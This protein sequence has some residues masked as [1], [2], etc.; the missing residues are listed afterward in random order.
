MKRTLASVLTGTL[1]AMAAVIGV[2]APASAA[3]YTLAGTTTVVANEK[4]DI[5]ITGSGY[6]DV[7]ALPGQ[8]GPGVYV[9]IVERGSAVADQ[10]S[11]PTVSVPV[12]ADGTIAST[13]SVPA[14]ALD[15]T[16]SYD[17]ISWPTRSVPSESNIFA[18]GQVEIDWNALFPPAPAVQTATTLS[19]S[20]ATTAVE[21]E[22]VLLTASV[23]PAAAGSVTFSSD[24]SALGSSPVTEG[25]AQLSTTTLAVGARSITASFTPADSAAFTASESVALGYTVTAKPVTPVSRLT[26]SQTEGL[27]PA[28]AQ[29]EI[30]GTGYEINRGGIYAQVGWLVEG[31]W[32]PLSQT[33]TRAANRAGVKSAWI[34]SGFAGQPAWTV[35][36]DGSGSFAWTVTVTQA[37]LDAKKIEGATLAVFTLGAHSNFVQPA[38]E[39]FVP[40]AFAAT[41]VEPQPEPEP[42]VSPKVTVMPTSALDPAVENVLTVSGTGFT[43]PAA[44]S[45]AYV[46]FGPTATW[47]GGSAFPRDW[48]A[49]AWVMPAQITEGAFT[50]TLTVPAGAIDPG[51]TYQ[52]VTSAAHGLSVT[53]RTLDTFT[54]VT[55]AQPATPTIALSSS[56][57]RA[58][59]ELT[60]SGYAF[61]PGDSVVVT[62]NSDPFTLGTATVAG[63]GRFSVTGTIPAT[64]TA[65]AHTVTVAVNGV[66]LASQ[67]FTVA[68]AAA[69]PAVEAPQAASCVARS[70][71]G[72]SIEWGVK[73]SF[74]TYITGSTANGEISG[75]WGTGSGAYSTENDRGRVSFGGS[76]HYT[77]HGG[78]LDVTLSNPRI[79]VTGPGSALLILNVQSLGL[80][81]EPGVNANGV[82]FANLSLPTASESANRISWNGA[83]ATLTAAGAEA[84]A[85][86]YN[87]GDA[88]DAV[89]FSFPLGAEV[90]C[91]TTTDATLAATGGQA[92]ID[93]IWLGAGALL[94]GALAISIARRRGVEGFVG[95]RAQV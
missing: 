93:T 60:V 81:G 86:F 1:V 2:S 95:G 19:A 84:F 69:V 31:E 61:T 92:P 6:G 77:G 37:E 33:D 35:A 14:T 71:S 3:S 7:Q 12:A 68:A 27:D 79:Q 76:I 43:G 54:P 75:G 91:D 24:G 15:R 40:I 88:L 59:G 18:R 50:A 51:Q 36:D 87:A 4:V 57:V 56:E 62:V 63:D 94:L 8:A 39:R 90:P 34:G 44:A 5:A 83:S 45:G 21:G 13:L 42:E 82:V 49:V 38:N 32:T 52:V 55:I 16:K 17:L 58:G 85:G 67:A 80:G 29:L 70:V 48:D 20:P 10:S 28:G 23:A 41:P 72:A 53:D 30:S 26:V 22:K 74:R 89:S 47:S 73:E 64:V 11:T 66:V 78:L 46:A 65:G 25:S 9:A